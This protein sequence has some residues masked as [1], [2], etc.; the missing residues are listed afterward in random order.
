MRRLRAPGFMPRRLAAIVHAPG[1]PRAALAMFVVALTSLF[2]SRAGAFE[3]S[4]STTACPRLGDAAR[5]PLRPGGSPLQADVDGDGRRDSVAVRYAPRAR[6]SCGFV[7]VV[8]AGSRV[9]AV[10]V[11]ESYKPPQDLRI[12]D[13]PFPEPYLAAAV[14]LD[15]DRSQIVVARSHGASVANISLYGVVDGTLVPLRFHPR[16]PDDQLSLFGTVG[17]GSTYARCVRGGPLIVMEIRPRDSS[18]R[19]WSAQRSKYRLVGAGFWRI[20]TLTVNGSRRKID[21]LARRWKMGVVA[22][23]TGCVV[24]R[25]RRL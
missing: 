20:R 12:R 8:K 18:G 6:A 7:L 25:G 16:T 21:A 11:P 22:P 14:K 23:F 15:A 24:A 19:R 13:W 4:H 1:V 17:T 3:S 10:R 9:F 5:L 2:A